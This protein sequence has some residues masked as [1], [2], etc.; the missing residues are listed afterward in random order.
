MKTILIDG[1]KYDNIEE[2]HNLFARGFDWTYYGNNLDALWDVL[3]SEER[4]F[5]I[6]WI[7]VEESKKKIGH[8][9]SSM[10]SLLRKVEERDKQRYPEAERFIFI[11]E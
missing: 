2:I 10:I 11:V 8:D 5:E 3:T 1:E 7:N 4:P 9:C 6:K